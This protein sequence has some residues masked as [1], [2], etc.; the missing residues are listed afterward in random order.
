M[1]VLRELAKEIGASADA[2]VNLVVA[3]GDPLRH[4]A[5]RAS[6]FDLVTLG[7][8]STQTLDQAPETS[9]SM[10]AFDHTHGALLVAPA[11]GETPFDRQHAMTNAESVAGEVG[12]G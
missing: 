4:V 1:D 8:S 3:Q 2:D 11:V 9:V 7:A 10:V 12:P 5:E 6:E